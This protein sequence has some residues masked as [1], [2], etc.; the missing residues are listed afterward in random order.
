[1]KIT[2][3]DDLDWLDA[4]PTENVASAELLLDRLGANGDSNGVMAQ[5]LAGLPLSPRLSRILVEALDR[6]VGEDGCLAAAMLGLGARSEKND[7]LAAMDLPQDYRLRQHTEQLLRMARPPKQT[8]HDDETLLLS[9]L[10]GF[11]DRVARR[12]IGN[13]I[14]LSTGIS[15]E[16][17]GEMP[18]YEF[19]LAIDAEDRK[20][21]PLPLIRMTARIEP[22]WLL[23]LFPDRIEERSNVVWNRTTE[24]VEKSSALLYDKLVIEESRGAA[25]EA[26][27][28]E[29]LAQKAFEVGIDQFVERASL[30]YFLARLTFAGLEP[31][32]LLEALRELCLGL[33]SFGDL[34]NVSKNLIPL[35]EQKSNTKLLNEVAPLSVRLKNGRQTKVHYQE[36]RPP[37][38]SSRLQDF[39]GMQDSPRIGPNKTPLVIHLLAPNHR[40]A[41]T[42][43]DLA[44][45]WKNLYPQVR[46]ELM[47]RYPRHEW[48]EKP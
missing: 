18:P 16:V 25:P 40:A 34:R 1:M 47:R 37:W 46:R 39:F 6:G 48:P 20:E 15:A 32:S 28:A 7:L 33:R 27:A 10:A 3:L 30:E 9:V 14:L 35:L 31:P 41:Q 19:M 13:Q 26:E 45:F 21:N 44:G 42:T 24:R 8:R 2:H 17:A 43:T 38:I 36:G 12:R 11:P 23:D 22:E 4:P 5:R 29:L